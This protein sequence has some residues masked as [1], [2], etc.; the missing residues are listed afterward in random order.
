MTC[1]KH[2]ASHVCL[3]LL[4]DEAMTDVWVRKGSPDSPVGEVQLGFLSGHEKGDDSL[5]HLEPG[6]PA[7]NGALTLSSQHSVC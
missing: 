2:L 1:V 7:D 3:G 4:G 5:C 6:G